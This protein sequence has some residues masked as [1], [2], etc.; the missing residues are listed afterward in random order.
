VLILEFSPREVSEEYRR[1]DSL[2]TNVLLLLEPRLEMRLDPFQ[3]LPQVVQLPLELAYVC[4]SFLSA[5]G[6]GGRVSEKQFILS[7]DLGNVGFN[8]FLEVSSANSHFREIILVG[9]LDS[10]GI[11]VCEGDETHNRRNR[12]QESKYIFYDSTELALRCAV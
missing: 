6:V 4:Q 7:D 1:F 5:I 3:F 2:L 10:G 9:L 8:C 11:A 12:R